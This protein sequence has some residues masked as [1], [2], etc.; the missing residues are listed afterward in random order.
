MAFARGG[1]NESAFDVITNLESIFDGAFLP[2][3]K[4]EICKEEFI[5]QTFTGARCAN[6]NQRKKLNF[7]T[8]C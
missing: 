3:E 5:K 8:T 7:T 4:E 6:F 2:D 1:N